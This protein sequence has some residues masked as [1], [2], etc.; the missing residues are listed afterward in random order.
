[1]IDECSLWFPFF[2]SLCLFTSFCY[3]SIALL[4]RS[5]NFCCYCFC[6][7]CLCFFFSFLSLFT[8]AVAPNV[9]HHHT[10]QYR[11]P[12]VRAVQWWIHLDDLAA[13]S[14]RKGKM[15][16]QPSVW[17]VY[18]LP[19]FSFFLYIIYH[20]R[21][22]SMISIHHSGSHNTKTDVIGSSTEAA[23]WALTEDWKYWKAVASVIRA[24]VSMWRWVNGEKIFS[25]FFS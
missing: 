16:L 25:F 18:A 11:I 14:W 21:L 5:F 7:G 10:P 9:T 17:M 20:F 8:A 2:F 1:M 12:R 3:Y 23:S 6:G 22:P 4:Y 13:D 24:M 19:S 15:C